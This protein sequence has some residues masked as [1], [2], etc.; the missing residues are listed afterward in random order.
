MTLF[1]RFSQN[2]LIS[3]FSFDSDITFELHITALSCCILHYFIVPIKRTGGV[4]FCERGGRLL[5]I[6]F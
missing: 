6:D 4:A 1:V 2:K 3:Q 5:G